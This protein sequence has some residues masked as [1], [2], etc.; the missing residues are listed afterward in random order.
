MFSAKTMSILGALTVGY[1]PVGT[2][3]VL[4]KGKQIKYSGR[5]NIIFHSQAQKNVCTH[6]CCG[7]GT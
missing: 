3:K 6:R 2:N 1:L 7:A 4:N 5:T